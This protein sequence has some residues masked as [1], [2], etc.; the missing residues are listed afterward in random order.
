MNNAPQSTCVSL[1]SREVHQRGGP[2]IKPIGCAKLPIATSC[3]FRHL[4]GCTYWPKSRQ[5]RGG[6]QCKNPP[7][8]EQS[9]KVGLSWSA[10]FAASSLSLLK[11]PKCLTLPARISDMSTSK[12]PPAEPTQ[13]GSG[14]KLSDT[15]PME[16]V[17]RIAKLPVVESSLNIATD[18]YS[19]MKV[20]YSKLIFR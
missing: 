18:M 2:K 14:R 11:S 5:Q 13:N 3:R 20:G 15:I 19:R 6:V 1:R 8:C 4:A 7:P 16:A 9:S 17:Q 12:P 10:R